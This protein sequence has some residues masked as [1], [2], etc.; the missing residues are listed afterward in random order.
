MHTLRISLL[1]LVWVSGMLGCQPDEA[2]L[3]PRPNILWITCE[4]LNPLLAS[5]GDAQA[6]T[7]HLDRLAGQSVQYPHAFATAAVC[8]PARACLIT[9]VYATTLGTQ[10][11]RSE[12]AVPPSVIPFPKLLRQA[13]YY[14]SN[15]YKEDY[16][17][18]DSTIWDA[19]SETA[20]WRNRDPKQPFF[21]VFNLETTHQS[22][23]FGSDSVFEA[24]LGHRL[25]D[26]LKHAPADMAL[27]PYYPDRPEIRKM[28]ARY[29]DLVSI[30]DQEVGDILAQ[31]EAD[32][33]AENTVV[34]FYADHGTG[35]PRGK[36]ALYDTGTRVPLL[37]RVP[38]AY[39]AAWGI[40]PGTQTGRLVSF[41]DFAPTLL[42]ML[43]LEIPG[44]MQG[45]PFL[46]SALPPARR[47]V[48]ATADR[49]DEAYEI[50]RS[51]RT[52]RYKYI[53]NYLPQ[54][55]L[56]QPNYYTDQSEI[57]QAL[58]AASTADDLS[59]AQAAMWAP[60]RPVEEL[61]AV[62][63]D[64]YELHNLAGDPAYEEVLSALRAAHM[65]WVRRTHDTG[66]MPESYLHQVMGDSSAY[67]AAR[68][69][70]IF[71]LDEVL[72]LHEAIRQRDLASLG[73]GLESPHPVLRFWA[74][75][76]MDYLQVE[77][78][79]LLQAGARR[80]KDTLVANRLVAA[81]WLTRMGQ[82]DAALPVIA[83]T[84][85]E[86]A[87]LDQLLAARTYELLG[88][89]A[90]PIRPVAERVKKQLAAQTRGQWKGYDLYAYWA[91]IEALKNP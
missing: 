63:D 65:D 48:F 47:Q 60:Q 3:P 9:G 43:N 73:Q 1:S 77:E 39:Q 29:Y 82:G 62:G 32:G 24:R 4:D 2:S 55:P 59:E 45:I 52:D 25:A 26:S 79:A 88:A 89:Q 84:L 13:G 91:L 61:Y 18:S 78:P 23:I 68:H 72:A 15:N 19:S 64:P 46:G 81:G 74:L 44:Y 36:R 28:V 16:N 41:V 14:C 49:V 66:L 71:P 11:L 57:M 75:Q 54:L 86:G 27:P 76:G 35:M 5:Y 31:L 37:V 87:P 67:A 33:L 42:H 70:E 50:T 30:M 21:A 80:L 22:R 12:V 51:V 8:S 6:Y 20:H 17:F 34:F 85:Q 10:N 58:R 53:R 7:P 40:Q 38:D 56:I 90:A 69:P 83:A